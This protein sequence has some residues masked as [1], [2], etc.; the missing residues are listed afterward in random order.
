MCLRAQG[1]DGNDGSV[2]RVIGASVISND[3]RG[4]GRGR[5]IHDAPEGSETTTEVAGD[6][7]QARVIYDDD[8]VVRRVRRDHIFSTKDGGV[9]R[10]Q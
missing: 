6:I 10:R 1:I 8:G 9:G 5:G 7:Q 3:D 4:F 2:G